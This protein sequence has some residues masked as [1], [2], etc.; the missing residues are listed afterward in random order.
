M[1]ILKLAIKSR[2]EKPPVI[3]YLILGWLGVL[4]FYN[5]FQKIGRLSV[6][7]L[8]I[9]GLCYSFGIIFYRWRKLPFNH[10]IWHIF[11]ILG[12]AF[13]YFSVLLLA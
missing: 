11:V 4:I 5:T 8:V 1:L 2:F 3:L 6:W 7:F 12:S 9:G 13:H 10:A